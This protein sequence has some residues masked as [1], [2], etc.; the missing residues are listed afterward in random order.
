M[1]FFLYVCTLKFDIF[2][3]CPVTLQSI[4]PG[5]VAQ[6]VAYLTRDLEVTGSI[7]GCGAFLRAISPLPLTSDL[8]EKV[9][10]G[11]ERMLCKY[12]CG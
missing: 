9:V 1:L 2:H 3:F 11:F 4:L 6:L 12:W 10:S 8:C 5:R 7:P